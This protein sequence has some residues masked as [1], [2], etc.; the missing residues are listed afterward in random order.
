MPLTGAQ[1]LLTEP[2]IKE[3]SQSGQ[4]DAHSGRFYSACGTGDWGRARR[5]ALMGE[6]RL[7]A[8]GWILLQQD[9]FLPSGQALA[10]PLGFRVNTYWKGQNNTFAALQMEMPT[11]K[12]R[13]QGGICEHVL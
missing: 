4:G 10:P 6:R 5:A 13:F 12:A 2:L 9:P 1:Q 8:E 11:G 7:K 3:W